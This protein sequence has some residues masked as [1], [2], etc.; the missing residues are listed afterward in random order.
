MVQ[1]WPSSSSRY[2]QGQ[3]LK[4]KLEQV[5]RNISKRKANLHSTTIFLCPQ[6]AYIGACSLLSWPDELTAFSFSGLEKEDESIAE[7]I[8]WR[9]DFLFNYTLPLLLHPLFPIREAEEELWRQPIAKLDLKKIVMKKLLTNVALP[10]S[11]PL[12][13]WLPFMNQF[14]C[15]NSVYVLGWGYRL[16]NRNGSQDTKDDAL[17]QSQET[18]NVH[19][20]LAAWKS[21]SRTGL[22]VKGFFFLLPPSP[23]PSGYGKGSVPS[24]NNSQ[25]HQSLCP[26]INATGGVKEHLG[27]KASLKGWPG[28]GGEWDWELA[29]Q[30]G[31]KLY[32]RDPAMAAI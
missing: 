14:D 15:I 31:K 4:V 11:I 22:I 1:T 19:H 10:S 13:P 27:L 23:T 2:I 32:E 26:D 3:L 16:W 17:T 5:K 30:C 12:L 18:E 9:R 29:Q 24:M 7:E 20:G 8:D 6:G 25:G 21:D 28:R